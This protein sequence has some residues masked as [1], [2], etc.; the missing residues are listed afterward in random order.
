MLTCLALQDNVD[1]PDNNGTA[2]LNIASTFSEYQ[3][4]RL[5]DAGVDPSRASYENST[6]LQLAARS[7]R[8][9]IIGQ[10]LDSL[11][12]QRD[13]GGV[14][15]LAQSTL[16]FAWTSGLIESAKLLIQ[17]GEKLDQES[18]K[19]S[20]WQF[21]AIFGEEEPNRPLL[22]GLYRTA[23]V[24]EILNPLF[25]PDA[26]AMKLADKTRNVDEAVYHAPKPRLGEALELLISSGS[27]EMGEVDQAIASAG[28]SS[29]DYTVRCKLRIRESFGNKGSV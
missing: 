13:S 21:C 22:Q 9:N 19:N 15:K 14:A 27:S 6:P 16:P 23:T 29:W 25:I 24:F 10:L 2:A 12:A 1:D 5:L 4:R 20:S 3:T 17:A 18:F 7:Q 26:R 11:K 8:P 28:K